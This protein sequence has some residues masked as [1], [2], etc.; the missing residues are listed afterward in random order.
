M[1]IPGNIRPGD[2]AN[3]VNLARQQNNI[4]GAKIAVDFSLTKTQ[5]VANPMLESSIATILPGVPRQGVQ[6]VV[7][8]STNSVK[9]N[10]QKAADRS[11]ESDRSY[12]SED[13][14]ISRFTNWVFDK[15]AGR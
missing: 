13:S 3:E 8:T 4:Q 11:I 6:Y 1:A 12:G 15:I 7:N 10:V 2:L 14:Y 9:N 5:Q